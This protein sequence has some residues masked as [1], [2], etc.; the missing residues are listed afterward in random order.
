MHCSPL[1]SKICPGCSAEFCKS[2][3]SLKEHKCS[4]PSAVAPALLTEDCFS[5]PGSEDDSDLEFTRMALEDAHEVELEDEDQSRFLKQGFADGSEAAMPPEGVVIHKI[6]KTAHKASE[7]CVA[8]CG[9]ASSDLMFESSIDVND[10]HGCKLCWRQGC[11]PWFQAQTE[12]AS[13]EE[14]EFGDEVP[15]V[16]V[17][18]EA[19]P[20]EGPEP[21]PSL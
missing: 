21:T 14:G 2:C 7:D 12:I 4:K 18:Y 20:T 1:C 16:F 17:P 5:E 15:S 11:A 10:L 13:S 8:V 3:N 19:S 6:Y 9:V